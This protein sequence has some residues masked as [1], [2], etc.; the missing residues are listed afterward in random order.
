MLTALEEYVESP[1]VEAMVRHAVGWQIDNLSILVG[2]DGI[3]LDGHAHTTLARV[4]TEEEAQR[5][6]DLPILESH[7]EVR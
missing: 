5:L 6:T 4:L 1:R 2:E 7:I 3:V